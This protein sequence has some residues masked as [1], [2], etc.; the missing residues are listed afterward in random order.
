M[1]PGNI[2]IAE[3]VRRSRGHCCLWR[4]KQDLLTLSLTSVWNQTASLLE[5]SYSVCLQS[6]VCG[7]TIR[8]YDVLFSNV[9]RLNFSFLHFIKLSKLYISKYI[10]HKDKFI[11]VLLSI[12]WLS[13]SNTSALLLFSQR[14]K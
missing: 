3:V 10:Y 9:S 13:T 12:Y 2:V 7:T 6:I 4:Q 1:S 14:P 5:D 8:Q 11:D